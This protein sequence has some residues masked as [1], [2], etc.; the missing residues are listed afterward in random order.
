[1][2]LPA[3]VGLVFNA[4]RE[5]GTIRDDAPDHRQ[6]AYLG[7]GAHR[8]RNPPDECALFAFVMSYDYSHG[9]PPPPIDAHAALASTQRFWR[10]WIGRFDNG[11]AHWPAQ[12]R[13][14]L[15]AW[16]AL[17]H[18]RSGGLIE[19]VKGKTQA[20]NQ[21]RS[22]L[23]SAPQDIRE[24]L[25]S[26]KMAEC[27]ANC[28]RVR[29]LR[30]T[31]MLQT[32]AATLRLLAKRCIALEEELMA[33][34]AML[35]KLTSLHAPRNRDRVGVGPHTA[36][37]LVT[38]AGDNPERLKSEASLAALC[39]TSLLQA[40]SG[41]TVRHRLNRGGSRSADNALWTIAMVRMRSDPRTCSVEA[42]RVC[43]TRRFIA[44]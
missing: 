27:V 29:S 23:V 38:V 28:A 43:R 16:K 17:D 44:A 9:G 6:F 2:K 24:R 30:N 31:P 22:L 35:E 15:I 3:A 4:G 14:S 19:V 36:A 18:Q 1:L 37:I 8:A 7:A 10:D 21:L 25:S 20:I 13:R 32:L 40:S 41:K 39:G 5:P 12:V 34:D 11:K 33:L 42:M 26:T